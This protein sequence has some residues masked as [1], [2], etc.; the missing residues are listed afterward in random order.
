V[1]EKEKTPSKVYFT[2]IN[3]YQKTKEINQAGKK[4]LQLIQE[5]EAVLDFSKSIPIKVHF[6]EEVCDTFI[7][8]KNFEDIISYLKSESKLTGTKTTPNIFYTETNVLYKGKRTT[9]K[10]HT[11]L[12]KEH[13]FTNLPIIIADGEM[14][15]DYIEVDISEIKSKH[16]NKCK[17]GKV[18]ATSPQLILIAHFKGH[19]MAGF[20]GALKQL[21]MGCAARG[22]KLAMH[23][24]AKPLLNPV[25]CKKCHTC[26][27][28]C[29]ADAC[30][31]DTLVPHVDN[32]KCI[33]CAKCIAVCPYDAMK[34]NWISTLP[35]TFVE[36]VADF[37]YAAQKGK[38]V[39]YLNYVLNIT[40]ECDCMDKK[41]KPIYNDIGIL[42]STDPVALDKA[43][44]DL[45]EK[46]I[47][48]KPFGG[49]HILDYVKTTGFGNTDYELITV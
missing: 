2:P 5:K 36:K 17:I 29:P 13:G 6:G 31:I 14:G 46:S 43:C 35:N 12:A 9:R 34:I 20:G 22:G 4:L 48:K 33:G 42:A 3:S 39:I 19:M 26:A 49:N 15:E 41:Q 8:P 11:K 21:A 24:N 23:S 25:K 37:A 44:F 18:I 10:S 1:T 40:K 27:K 32:N 28:N 45:L 47:N 16:F 38:K 30:I 7:E